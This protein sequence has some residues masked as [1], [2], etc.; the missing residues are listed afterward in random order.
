MGHGGRA[1][2]GQGIGRRLLEERLQRLRKIPRVRVVK[3]QTSQH[4]YGFF[5]KA[6]FRTESVKQDGYGPGLHLYNMGLILDEDRCQVVRELHE[7]YAA[8]PG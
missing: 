8:A 5:E 7:A 6:G 2:H 4:T 1:W 3:L